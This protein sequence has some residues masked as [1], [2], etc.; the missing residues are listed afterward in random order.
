MNV[1]LFDLVN[2]EIVPSIH[3][4]TI[5]SFVNLEE[6]YGP[7]TGKICACFHYMLSLNPE[8]NPFAYYPE[9]GKWQAINE[10]VLPELPLDVQGNL[11]LSLALS[12]ARE[13]YET[14]PYRVYKA[15]KN[16]LDKLVVSIDNS[17]IDL[18]KD[19][20]NIAQIKGVVAAYADIKKA[21]QDSF[22]EFMKSFNT[23]HFHCGG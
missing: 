15:F 6:E 14:S 8:D 21:Y 17:T 12:Q 5:S 4:K 2:G 9:E 13:M 19:S 7:N 22:Q 16:L 20:G 1:K 18:T 10:S 23:T 11:V 3:C